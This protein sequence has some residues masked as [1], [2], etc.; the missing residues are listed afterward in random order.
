VSGIPSLVVVANKL[1]WKVPLCLIWGPGPASS[2]K[3]DSLDYARGGLGYSQ[4]GHVR[5]VAKERGRVE[6]GK[7]SAATATPTSE[8][9]W[10]V[11]ADDETD[12]QAAA[13]RTDGAPSRAEPGQTPRPNKAGRGEAGALSA[14]CDPARAP[15]RTFPTSTSSSLRKHN[16]PDPLAFFS[17]N[18]KQLFFFL[19]AQ[20]AGW[21]CL[22]DGDGRRILGSAGSS[23]RPDRPLDLPVAL[24]L[25]ACC[26]GR[27]RRRASPAACHAASTSQQ[28]HGTDGVGVRFALAAGVRLVY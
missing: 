27:R 15:S 21:R 25:P 6:E 5:D 2:T 24:L 4:I 17:T 7:P 14:S 12:E 28:L 19:A 9:C 16:H 18:A 23:P 8:S 10:F 3:A 13:E 11:L 26:H 20:A 22:R 1:K